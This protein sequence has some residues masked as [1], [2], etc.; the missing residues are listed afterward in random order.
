ML[1][2]KIHTDASSQFLTPQSPDGS[3]LVKSF[4]SNSYSYPATPNSN[5]C[6]KFKTSN[7]FASVNNDSNKLSP[8]SIFADIR[9]TRSASHSTCSVCCSSD[10]NLSKYYSTHSLSE[11]HMNSVSDFSLLKSKFEKTTSSK[12]IENV[13]S[14]NLPVKF[15][16]TYQDSKSSNFFEEK[17]H[18]RH[19]KHRSLFSLTK[20][21]ST[22]SSKLNKASNSKS[23]VDIN[24]VKREFNSQENNSIECS[25]SKVCA[26]YSSERNKQNSSSTSAIDSFGNTDLKV[27]KT[28][29][30][31][32]DFYSY[33]NKKYN[34]MNK[35]S[36]NRLRKDK[37]NSSRHRYQHPPIELSY[38]STISIKENSV[39]EESN[40]K[41]TT[42]NITIKYLASNM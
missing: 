11:F 33:Y 9:F 2:L 37:S 36:N 15:L 27:D 18:Q 30:N 28:K 31:L 38:M 13:L 19:N 40:P 17:L 32:F 16:S 12:K 20:S 6:S 7:S 39:N 23:T 3:K 25:S 35:N 22:L 26:N 24:Q 42:Q 8:P 5:T 41:S 10:W 1:T 4:R 29:R 34:Q 14:E 21:L